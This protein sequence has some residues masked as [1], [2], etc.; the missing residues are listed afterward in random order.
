[1]PAPA[2]RHTGVSQQTLAIYD[3][4]LDRFMPPSFL[5]DEHGQ[6]V[7]TFGGVET[8]LKIKSRRPTQNLLDLLGDDFRTVVSGVLHR[9]R[10]DLESV[11]YPAVAISGDSRQYS[12]IAEPLLDAQGALTH[13]LVSIAPSEVGEAAVLVPP[14]ADVAG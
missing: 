3:R 10:R 1:M 4:L 2:P 7:D 13:I 11:R 6:L 5:V 8:L 12:L 9:V 14:Y